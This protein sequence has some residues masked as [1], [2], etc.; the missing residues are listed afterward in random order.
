MARSLFPRGLRFAA[1]A[2]GPAA[3]PRAPRLRQAWGWTPA[4]AVFGCFLNRVGGSCRDPGQLAWPVNKIEGYRRGNACASPLP[5]RLAG[6]SDCWLRARDSLQSSSPLRRAQGGEYRRGDVQVAVNLLQPRG[7]HVGVFSNSKLRSPRTA[8]LWSK[9]VAAPSA[10]EMSTSSWVASRTREV[11]LVMAAM[12]VS[13]NRALL[14]F[15]CTTKAGRTLP[16][17]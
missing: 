8:E 6:E 14:S 3:W 2:S 5:D 12:I 16:P 11:L 9:P 7:K 10:V 13:F 4:G 15:D 1:R 17:G